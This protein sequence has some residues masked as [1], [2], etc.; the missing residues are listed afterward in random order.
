MTDKGGNS[1]LSLEQNRERKIRDKVGADALNNKKTEKEVGFGLDGLIMESNAARSGPNAL[2]HEKS[3]KRA[4]KTPICNSL[5][6][7]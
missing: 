5:Y 6:P 1:R 2:D 7:V 4:G 3:N